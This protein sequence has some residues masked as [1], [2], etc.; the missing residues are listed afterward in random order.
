MTNNTKLH[1]DIKSA[2]LRFAALLLTLLVVISAAF[3]GTA[4]FSLAESKESEPIRS[5]HKVKVG[6]K[7]YCCFVTDNVILSPKDIKET[8]D[9]AVEAVSKDGEE[10]TDEA[11]NAAIDDA[12]TAM[13]LEKAGFYMKE[14]NCTES[15]HSAITAEDWNKDKGCILLR[16]D[17]LAA[18]R[19]ADPAEKAPVKLYMDLQLTT[20]KA[21]EITEDTKMYSTGTLTGPA[22][23]FVAVATESDIEI[24][25]KEEAACEAKKEES[26]TEPAAEEQ[27]QA[28]A[29]AVKKPKAPKAT[30]PEETLPEFK[31][32]KMLDRSGGPLEETLK[33][34]DPVTLEWRALR[35]N[36][37]NRNSSFLS[38]IPGGAL[39]L[40]AIAA[41]GAAAIYVI[42][43]R[44]KEQEDE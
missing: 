4:G 8:E 11:R 27:P 44:K 36:A 40:A 41:A 20:E 28:A 42:V 17:D 12:I 26:K 33:E 9:A 37:S 25:E 22:L 31:T 19:G 18:I 13:V 24:T 30:A 3:A 34:G 23:L 38:R 15:S 7:K 14:P 10:L 5:A 39:S 1:C 6:E 32:I 16:N 2:L 35:R 29:P 43:R 21:E